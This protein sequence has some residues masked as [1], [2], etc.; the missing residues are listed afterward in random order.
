MPCQRA[1]QSLWLLREGGEGEGCVPL[2]TQSFT[3]GSSAFPMALCKAERKT[4]SQAT[5]IRPPAKQDH[6]IS[7]AYDSHKETELDEAE[8]VVAPDVIGHGSVPQPP[9]DS[10]GWGIR[11]CLSPMKDVRKQ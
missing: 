5:S 3:S 1:P 6:L 11:A 2:S 7:D 10:D 8:P 4:Y 9:A